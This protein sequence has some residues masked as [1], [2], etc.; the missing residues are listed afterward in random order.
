MSFAVAWRLLIVVSSHC[1]DRI[2][3]SCIS[4][5]HV[6]TA[7][8]CMVERPSPTALFL[9]ANTLAA[10]AVI[11]LLNSCGPEPSLDHI[12]RAFGRLLEL[13]EG[14]N[15]TEAFE[16]ISDMAMRQAAELSG[17]VSIHSPLLQPEYSWHGDCAS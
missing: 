9:T 12:C 13:D 16:K 15:T 5:T 14:G 17:Q 2:L 11:E 3:Q 6:R 4:D 7:F 10:E 8:A 1:L